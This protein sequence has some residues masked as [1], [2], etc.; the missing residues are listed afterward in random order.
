MAYEVWW[1]LTCSQATASE[2]AAC[3]AG[4]PIMIQGN[5]K[6]MYSFLCLCYFILC[7]DLL[8]SYDVHITLFYDLYV[9]FIAYVALFIAWISLYSY[10][11]FTVFYDLY[12]R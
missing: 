3:M 8:H 10:D 9:I 4:Q 7:K 1:W 2:A 12:V 5:H 6:F 11:N